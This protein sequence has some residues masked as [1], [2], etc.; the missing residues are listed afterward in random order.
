MRRTLGVTVGVAAGVGALALGGY[1]LLSLPLSSQAADPAASASPQSSAEPASATS[2]APTQ[3]V[4]EAAQPAVR[5]DAPPL[6]APALPASSPLAVPVQAP[7]PAAAPVAPPAPSSAPAANPDNWPLRSTAALL[8]ERSQGDWRVVRWQ[9]NPAVAVLQFPDLAQQGAALNRLAALVEKGGAPRD[10]LLGS[11]ELLQLIQAGGDNPQTFFGGHNYRLSQL[12]RFHG[13]A[14]RQGI[15]LSPEEQRLRQLFEAQGWWGEQAADKV[16]ITFT[17]LQAD[18]PGTPQDEGVDAVR[19]ESVLRHELS[20]ARYFT[21]PRYRARCGEM[22]RQWLN[23]AERQ[24]IRKVLAEQ[25]YDA[26]NEDLLINEAQALLFHTADTRAF[27]AAS[28]GLTEA[29]LTALR[30]RFHA[31][32]N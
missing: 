23:A 5:Q 18:D 11:A 20:H 14:N 15:G 13:L 31:S 17:D 8:A 26:Q 9:E 2:P 32:A 29:R 7:P 4:A 24:R 19:R 28:F 16:L 21:D 6:S 22:W 30:K 27:G 12:L 1:W 10:R 3:A 25:G